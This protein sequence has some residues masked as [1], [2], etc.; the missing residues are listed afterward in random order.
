MPYK[1]E[2]Y[3]E[4]CL[5]CGACTQCNNWELG[6]DRKASPKKTELDDVGCNREAEE[7]C[8]VKAIKIIEVK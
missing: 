4:K 2:F 7:I 6:K 1:I 5:G 8:P 3:K